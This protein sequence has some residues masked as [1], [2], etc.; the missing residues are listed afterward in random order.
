MTDKLFTIAELSELTGYPVDALRYLIDMKVVVP[1]HKIGGTRGIPRALTPTMALVLLSVL[2][3]HKALTPGRPLMKLAAIAIERHCELYPKCHD[4]HWEVG[5]RT[6]I[7]I[8][9]Q[10]NRKKLGLT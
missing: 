1:R 9:L 3:M 6:K 7:I 5:P 2:D 10:Q 8:E 4:M